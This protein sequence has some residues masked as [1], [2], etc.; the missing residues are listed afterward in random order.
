MELIRDSMTLGGRRVKLNVLLQDLEQTHPLDP[1]K[2][3]EGPNKII[4][5]KDGV[6]AVKRLGGT[7]GTKEQYHW[8]GT[9]TFN[10]FFED[11]DDDELT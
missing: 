7:L 4:F 9:F 10:D 8:I 2:I 1:T 3:V 11:D 6:V 5:A